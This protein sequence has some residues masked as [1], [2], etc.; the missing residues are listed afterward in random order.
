MRRP[1]LWQ[2][3]VVLLLIGMA[4][5]SLPMLGNGLTRGGETAILLLGSMGA[6]A[7]ILRLRRWV[8]IMGLAL[9][10]HIIPYLL[11]SG[12]IGHEGA[13]TGAFFL[14]LAAAWLLAWALVTVLAEIRTSRGDV[15][16]V[17][18]LIIPVI[19]GVWILIIWEAVT[20]G[21]GI[22][23]ILLPPPSAIFVK[24]ISS[25]SVI[26]AD[27]TELLRDLAGRGVL[28]AAA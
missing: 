24:L 8:R 20:R 27:V 15:R 11:F 16:M 2:P 14:V 12:L 13:A 5:L 28:V 6:A 26:A 21:L 17:L 3:W 7:G 4:W 10:A 25:L 18:S 19:F 23:F 1:A 22:P 9:T